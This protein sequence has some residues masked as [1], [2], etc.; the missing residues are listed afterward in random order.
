[1][2]LSTGAIAHCPVHVRREK[3]SHCPAHLETLYIPALDPAALEM[4]LC[5]CVCVCVCVCACVCV[6][7]SACT[8][9]CEMGGTVC[10]SEKHCLLMPEHRG[11]FL[12]LCAGP[13]QGGERAP[14]LNQ[15]SLVPQTQFCS[16]LQTTPPEHNMHTCVCVCVCVKETLLKGGLK[17]SEVFLDI[18]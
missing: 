14:I 5:V 15:T 16:A 8:R 1:M 18:H 7:V 17:S 3:E 2:C 4:G 13:G 9:V 10:F 6:C 11:A 12:S